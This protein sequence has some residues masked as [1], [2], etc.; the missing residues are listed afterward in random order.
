MRYRELLYDLSSNYVEALECRD[1]SVT[2]NRPDIRQELINVTKLLRTSEGVRRDLIYYTQTYK[3]FIKN[4]LKASYSKTGY[5]PENLAKAFLRNPLA[6]VRNDLEGIR[7]ITELRTFVPMLIIDKDKV[8]L[9][10]ILRKAFKQEIF[11][12]FKTHLELS[13]YE[14]VLADSMNRPIYVLFSKRNKLHTASKDTVRALILFF[15]VP[16]L[17]KYFVKQSTS[18]FRKLITMYYPQSTCEYLDVKTIMKTP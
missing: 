12:G 5:S 16:G 7:Y 6:R 15:G 3:D 1:L 2:V 4:Y 10:L 13:G 14:L 17:P 18:I 8:S 11:P 9:P